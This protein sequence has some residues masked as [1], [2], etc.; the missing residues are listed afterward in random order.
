MHAVLEQLPAYNARDVERFIR[1]HSPAVAVEDGEDNE[2]M[3]GHH[4]M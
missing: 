1:V 2:L 3:K 4:Q